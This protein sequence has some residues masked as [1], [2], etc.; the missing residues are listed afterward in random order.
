MG[1]TTHALTV[2]VTEPEPKRYVFKIDKQWMD[3][4]ETIVRT[5]KDRMPLGA[6]VGVI[7]NRQIAAQFGA[8]EYSYSLEDVIIQQVIDTGDAKAF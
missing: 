6:A 2:T 8:V 4:A 5:T 7:I 3:A 1:A